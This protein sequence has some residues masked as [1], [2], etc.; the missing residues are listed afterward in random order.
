MRRFATFALLA[1]GLA[2]GC[3][4]NEKKDEKAPLPSADEM[5]DKSKVPPPLPGGGPA[6]VPKGKKTDPG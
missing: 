4:E 5:F 6:G 1:A 3:G 2:A